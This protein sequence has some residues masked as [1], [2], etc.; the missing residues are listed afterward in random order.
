MRLSVFA[1]PVALLALGPLGC[2]GSEPEPNTPTAG[3]YVA[4]PAPTQ[5]YTAPP[6]ATTAPPAA[7][8]GTGSTA[9]PIAVPAILSP[10]ITAM[11]ASEVKGMQPEGAPFAGQFSDGQTLE[12]D[13]NIAAG[14]CYSVVAAGVGMQNVQVKLV[15]QPMPQLPPTTLAQS[16][17]SG[18]QAVLGGGGNCF[19]NALP[20]GG[21]GKVVLTVTGGS[22]IAGAQ[23]YVK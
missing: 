1:L 13:I 19:K 17:G 3:Q 11:A 22:G 23:V 15:L 18:T 12:Q 4:P 2:G 10:V 16:A 6:T 14:K 5:A 9:T 7:A 20:V 21:P 8:G